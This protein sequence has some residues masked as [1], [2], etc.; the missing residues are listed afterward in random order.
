MTMRHLKDRQFSRP[1]DVPCLLVDDLLPQPLAP[2]TDIAATRLLG[3]GTHHGRRHDMA[4][5]HRYLCRA[6]VVCRFPGLS[7][8]ADRQSMRRKTEKS[9][10]T[11]GVEGEGIK[12][13]RQHSC[14]VHL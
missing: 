8:R 11:G 4:G 1:R 2:R 10:Q 9:R 6:C 13:G 7:S 14:G 5:E 12:F 3:N